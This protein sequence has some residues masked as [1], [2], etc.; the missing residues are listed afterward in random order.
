MVIMTDTA[1]VYSPASHTKKHISLLKVSSQ[2]AL[3]FFVQILRYPSLT[4]LLPTQYNGGEWNFV[5]GAHSTQNLFFKNSVLV[6]NA[7][8]PEKE[9]AIHLNTYNQ[10]RSTSHSNWIANHVVCN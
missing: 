8:K 10:H 6:F 3:G 5:L 1:R 2:I 7:E 9:H 4:F